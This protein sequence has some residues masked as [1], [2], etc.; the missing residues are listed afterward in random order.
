MKFGITQTFNCSY[1][2]DEHEQLLVYAEKDQDFSWR[3][4]QLIQAGFRRS[5]EQIYRPHCPACT[6]CQSI[7]VLVTQYAP[8]KSQRRLIKRN[9]HLTTR[10]SSQ[11]GEAYYPLYERYIIQRHAD[12]TMYPPSRQQFDSFIMCAWKKPVFIE[13]Y[14][15]ETLIAVAV[16]DDIDNGSDH[17]AFSA[18]YTFFDPDPGY[19]SLGSWMIIQQIEH[20]RQSGKTYLYLGYQIDN[21]NKMNYKRKFAPNERFLQN[22]WQSSDKIDL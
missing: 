18:L 15:G 1:L 8:S 22:K 21:C 10:L 12:G 19:H 13:A 17:Q 14:D 9:R 3:Y 6:A 2:E 16:T 5:G 4:G 20:A 11:P 7:R